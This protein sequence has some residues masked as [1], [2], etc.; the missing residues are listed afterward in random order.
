[1]P[2][3]PDDTVEA[4]KFNPQISGQPVLLASGSWDSVVRVWQINESG[5]SEARAQQNVGGPVL[6]LDWLDVSLVIT[7]GNIALVQDSYFELF[8]NR[9]LC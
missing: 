3:P 4:L 7:L 2:S 1:M 5:Q 6:D 8:H 9:T